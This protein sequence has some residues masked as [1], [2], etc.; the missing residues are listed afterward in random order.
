MGCREHGLTLHPD[1]THVC[2]CSQPEQGF[3]F[4]GYHF[5][6]GRRWV[7]KKSMTALRDKIRLKTPRS[8]GHSLKVV[9]ENLNPILRGW[10]NYYKHADYRTFSP[11]DGFVRRRLR[12]IAR[13]YL[14]K[15]GG[16][17]RCLND[18]KLWPNSHFAELGLFTMREAHLALARQPR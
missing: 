12:S 6:N 10:F 2:D 4:L 9:I 8:N 11:I 3:D 17:G 13:K 15:N 1:K 18:H 14:K 5:S 16:T 7:R